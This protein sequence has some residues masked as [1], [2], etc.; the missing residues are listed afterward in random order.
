[1]RSARQASSRAA[2]A[3][4][5]S[6]STA[7]ASSAALTAPASPIASVPTG[8]PA[9]I[10]T[11][12]SRLSWPDSAREGT[13]TPNTGSV[14]K[15]AVMPGQMRRA[16]G[17]GDDDLEPFRLRALGEGDEPVGRA[18]GGDDPR[19]VADAER[20]ERLGGAA[21]DRPVGLAA[22]DDGDGFLGAAQRARA[23][24]QFDEIHGDSD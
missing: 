15:A 23:E 1:M 9:G 11:I 7:Q 2:S 19:V 3:S 13:G 12:D 6:A 14:V 21:H 22:H 20:F 10:C 4:S 24:A 5:E 8:T 16:A 17:A 18:V